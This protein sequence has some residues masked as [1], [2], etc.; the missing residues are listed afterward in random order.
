MALISIFLPY[1]Y[2]FY[3]IC[4]PCSY[5][6]IYN[7]RYHK[8]IQMPISK[9]S[10][11]RGRN[12]ETFFWK[13]NQRLLYAMFV[14]QFLKYTI[15]LSNARQTGTQHRIVS[16]KDCEQNIDSKLFAIESRTNIDRS[17]FSCYIYR[18]T[19]LRI[20]KSRRYSAILVR[21]RNSSIIKHP[22]FQNLY[23]ARVA[24]SVLLAPILNT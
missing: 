9:A 20:I 5:V 3:I 15:N 16:M 7:S 23:I 17:N 10:A 12:F 21:T 13:Y 4:S 24:L 1:L 8:T 2:P 6:L 19:T 11:T 18:S 14:Q 22:A